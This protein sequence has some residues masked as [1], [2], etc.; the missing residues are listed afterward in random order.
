MAAQRQRRLHARQPDQSAR[1]RQPKP[2]G[3]AALSAAEAGFPAP[4]NRS[5]SDYAINVFNTQVQR[6]DEKSCNGGL[7][8]QIFTFNNGYN[9]KN[10]AS[11]GNFFVLAARL[12]RFTGNATYAEWAEKSYTWSRSIGLID[13]NYAVYDGTDDAD[14]CADVNRIQWSSNNGVMLE[15]A[16]LMYNLTQGN[17]T[18]RDITTGF[19]NASQ[20]FL[21]NASP[22]VLKEIACEGNGKCDVDQRA[23]KGLATRS[24]AR[25]ALSAPFL[26]D[27]VT[28]ML[29]A[30][31]KAA[32]GACKEGVYKDVEGG[33]DIQCAL[34]WD[35]EGSDAGV[36]D[37]STG[38]ASLE[39][40]QGLL[41]ARA[42]A[43]ET[44]DGKNE[45]V[46]AGVSA[47]SGAA[48]PEQTGAA[49]VVAG[50]LMA[51]L[52]VAFAAALSC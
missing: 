23:F 15:G 19:L 49:G 43:L 32:A 21:S 3:L 46:Q 22:P 14:N 11:N 48:A 50:S 26:A 42:K 38:L 8:W 13:E 10:M 34:I 4:Q 27:N 35:G 37:V 9:Y 25:A 20:V 16:A 1:Q 36:G 29:E 52:A 7:K 51:V 17:T 31:A 30:S 33:L 40:V 24:Y 28:V 5:W 39:A 12:A 45:T 6:W 2:L 47:T 44:K 41:W 18:W